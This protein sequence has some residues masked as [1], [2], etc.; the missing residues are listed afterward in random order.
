MYPNPF[1]GGDF[2]DYPVCRRIWYVEIEMLCT[3]AYTQQL[4]MCYPF[5]R[6]A[7][8][9]YIRTDVEV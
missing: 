1:S 8:K 2:W 3:I 4:R 7:M 5:A 6:Q 9:S